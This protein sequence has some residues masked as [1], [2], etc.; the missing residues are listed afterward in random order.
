[1]KHT[2]PIKGMHCASCALSIEKELNKLSEVKE[3]VVNYANEK[4]T[5]EVAGDPDI[6]KLKKVIGSVGNY[7][8][9]IEDEHHKKEGGHHDHGPKVDKQKKLMIWSIILTLGIFLINWF[10]DI[11]SKNLLM[12]ILSTPVQFYIGGQFY[13]ATW[14]ALKRFKANMDTLIA[15]GTSVAYFF[16]LA[17]IILELDLH[18]YF[19]TASAIITLIIVG[20]YLEARAKSKASNAIKKL[21]ELS[22]KKARI[23]RDNKE[24]EI[25]I[26]EVKVN[27][28]ILVKPGEKFP[29]D[30]EVIEGHSSVNESMVSGES[31]PVEKSVGDLVIGATINQNGVIKFKATKVGKD[32]MLAQIVKMVEEA[33]GSKAPIQRLADSISSVFV[34]TVIIIALFTF[35]SWYFLTDIGLASSIIYSVAVLVIACPCALGLATP[36]AIMVGSGRGAENGILI[37][38]AES[39]ERAHKI[40]TIVFD[41][42]GTITKGSPEVVNILGNNDVLEIA[43]A[44]EKNSEHPLAQAVINEAEKKKLTLKKVSDFKSV[45][46]RGIKASIDSN[47][48]LLGNLPFLNDNSITLSNNQEAEIT[49]AESMGQTALILAGKNEYLGVILVADQI[50]ETSKKA[51]EKLKDM[52]VKTIMLTGD[53]ELTAQAITK[54]VG[55]DQVYARLMPD[56]KVEKIKELQ[57]KSEVVAMV[58]DGINDAPALTQADVGLAIGT[59]TDIAIESANITLV[60]GDLLKVA[61][62]IKLSKKTVQNIKQNLFWA[63][64][65]NTIGIPLAA[66]G[67][68]APIFAAVAMSFSSISVVLNSLRLK[69]IKL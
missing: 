16:S 68:F 36:T 39:L 49:K 17:V 51:I 41:K 54:E 1:M 67:L 45:T 32:T 52:N 5:L 6:E 34:P 29:V 59:G 38:N 13:K 53:N 69:K 21:L 25:D 28:S 19:E 64:F 42:T 65:Y 47:T 33:Q 30:G 62:A 23:I 11:E 37:K 61:E 24:I 58:G 48:Y 2:Y 56:Q 14:P 63:F 27:D 4:L 18:V 44:L 15:M 26:S 8:L 35:L 57:K 50:K 66:F 43:Y 31:I 55:I 60:H 20:R 46:G 7:E 10:L 3:V 22:A 9:I 40:T 12:L